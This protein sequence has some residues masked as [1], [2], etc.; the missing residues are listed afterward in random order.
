[1][2]DAISLPQ[3]VWFKRD[4]RVHDHAPLRDALLRGPVL[5]LYVVEPSLWS[6]PD[7]SARHW[8]FIRGSLIDLDRELAG[9]GGRLDTRIGEVVAVLADLRNTLGPFVLHAHEETGTQLTYA[10]DRAVIAWCRA[11]GIEFR[12]TAQHGVIRRLG[13]RDGWSRRWDAFMGQPVATLPGTMRFLPARGVAPDRVSEPTRAEP[14]Q[15]HQAAGRSRAMRV[16]DSFLDRR[17]EHYRSGMSSPVTGIRECSRLSAY[18]AVGS[19]SMREAHQRLEARRAALRALPPAERGGWSQSLKSFSGRLHWHC[20][21][22]QKLETE[23]RIEFE[24]MASTLNGLREDAFDPAAF[25]AWQRGETGFPF[26]DACMRSLR[27]TGWL[28]FRMRAM[29][30]S[31]AAYDLWLHWIRP[32]HHLARLFLDYEPGIHISQ[33][34]MQSGTT[35]MNTLRIYNPVKQSRDQDPRGVFIRRWV[36]ELAALPDEYIHAPWETPPL[37]AN[38]CGIELGRDYPAPIVDHAAASKRARERISAV[39][40]TEAARR[41]RDENVAR[42]GSRKRQARRSAGTRAD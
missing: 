24:N 10:R 26:V 28:N 34:Q 8:A 33:M 13:N 5:P 42:H 1:M 29:L 16:L 25:D 18:L 23:P 6:A 11:R 4:L 3:I 20:H 21:F 36:P 40:R 27:A 22:I 9:L 35:G 31:F 17:A 32:S 30:V 39:R 7:R 14:A 15:Q 37:L 41:E 12:E 2:P 19:I 38:A